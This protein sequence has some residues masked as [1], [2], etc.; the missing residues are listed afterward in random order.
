[1]K[2][3][4]KILVVDDE[5]DLELLIKQ[6]YRQ[7]I[8]DNEISFEF[9]A[10]GKIALEKLSDPKNSFDMVLTD[11]NM[12]EMD[13]LTL[14]TKLKEQFRHFKAVVVSAYGDLDNIR[15]A[16]N[17][18]AFDFITKPIDFNDLTTTID[19]TIEESRFIKLGELAREQLVK[20]IKD[21]ERAEQSE[22]FK[23]Q[24]LANMSHEI[25]TPM[26]SIIGLT[27]LLVK[28]QLDGQQEKYLNIIKK[29]SENLLVIINDILDLSKIEAG[30]MDFEK[31]SFSIEETIETIHQSLHFK[32]VEKNL[33]LN[34][35]IDSSTP[36]IV[37]G[38]PTRLNQI[39]SNLTGNA[40]K[41]T[42][43]G[44]VMIDVREV[45]KQGNISMIQ[46][47]V[48]DSGIGISESQIHKIFD[49]FAQATSDTT[50]KF[51]GTGLGLTISKQLIELQGGKI[52]VKSEIGKGASFIF[53]IPYIIG[54]FTN[55]QTKK[56][57]TFVSGEELAGIHILLVEDNAFNQMVVTDTLLDLIPQ[58]NIEVAENGS[59]AVEM[60]KTN[61]YDIILMDIQMPVMDGF[62]A[63]KRI[64]ELNSPE[65][66]ISIMAMTANVTPDE[67]SKCFES[68]MD[69]YISKPFDTQDLLNK[70][71]KLTQNL[72]KI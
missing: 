30:K 51:G 40:V 21:K 69:A 17:H 11:I 28:T 68:G 59:I 47:S 25:R 24:F 58:L 46:F 43:S 20:T 32:A 4:A 22:K 19:K 71:G 45:N 57:R 67:I 42:E 23:Q 10:N 34:S 33:I 7:R 65:K 62:E 27:N 3:P 15:T 26:N 38:D 55:E 35:N 64:R 12:P 6:R 8:K 1:M 36:P 52:I 13:G 2:Q 14:L 49:S 72:P 16:M 61:N 37:I 63:T 31:T 39:L 48:I 9:A 18:G 66:N 44:T 29:S 53:T 5:P 56:S 50:R 70:I 60:V 41:F 54:D